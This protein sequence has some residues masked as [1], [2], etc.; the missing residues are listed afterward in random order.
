VD[1]AGSYTSFGVSPAGEPSCGICFMRNSGKLLIL[2]ILA[3]AVLMAGA[4]W[5]VRYRATHRA[6][7]FWGPTAARLIRDAPDVK[8]FHE[9]MVPTNTLG[10]DLANVAETG[11]AIKRHIGESAIDVSH[12]PGLLHLR[13]ALLEDAN[14]NWPSKKEDRPSAAE[15]LGFWWLQ[16]H[17]PSSG[18]AVIW[19]TQDCRQAARLTKRPDGMFDATP[20]SCEQIAP[21]LR[22]V[23]DEYVKQSAE[24]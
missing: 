24:R 19:F 21:G 1:D 6:A 3:L 12:R 7:E 9:P 14:F 2:G 4:S 15:D 20:I 23:F 22:E 5:W 13:N 17:D 10:T 16:F 11:A 8:L 18:T